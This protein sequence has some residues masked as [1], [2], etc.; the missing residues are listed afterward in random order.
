MGLEMLKS[1]GRADLE[2]LCLYMLSLGF[3]NLSEEAKIL[4]CLKFEAC[5]NASGEDKEIDWGNVNLLNRKLLA[6]KK[7]VGGMDC[8]ELLGHSLQATYSPLGT[9]TTS[10]RRWADEGR[11]FC[12]CVV[13]WTVLV[14]CT[15]TLRRCSMWLF[16]N[17]TC[18]RAHLE[19]P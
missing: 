3:E 1:G 19:S 14:N 18:S 8:G 11:L 9:W 5:M 6:K 17:H 13:V 12:C 2:R 7:R 10:V 16:H 15:A 4:E